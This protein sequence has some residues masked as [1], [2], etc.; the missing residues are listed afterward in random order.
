MGSP[1]A[2]FG[3][4]FGAPFGRVFGGIHALVRSNGPGAHGPLGLGRPQIGLPEACFRAYSGGP[5]ERFWGHIHALVRSNGPGPF[6]ALLRR[7][8]RM[9]LFGACFRAY[10]GGVLSR[11][12]LEY[13]LSYVQMAQG[14]S[15]PCSGGA[16]EW[17]P[18]RPILR[19]PRSPYFRGS[20]GFS[21]D[22]QGIPSFEP[23]RG[24]SKQ[25]FQNPIFGPPPGQLIW[26]KS[27]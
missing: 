10:S 5:F 26:A 4:L 16:S 23:P 19:P 17:A 11:Y 27:H 12:W 15:G 2:G 14:P 25:G 24:G 18:N 13:T 9:G 21:P 22:S 6:R 3:A 8:L 1:E 20:P 7:G